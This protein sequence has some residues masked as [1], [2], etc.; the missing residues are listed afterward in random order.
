MIEWN[1]ASKEDY[2]LVAQI[3]KRANEA[4][5][6]LNRWSLEMDI[7]ATHICGCPLKLTELLEADNG[8]FFYDILGIRQHIDRDTGELQNCFLPRYAV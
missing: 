5:P 6:D 7:I 8:N 3:T 2:E 1:K 4:V